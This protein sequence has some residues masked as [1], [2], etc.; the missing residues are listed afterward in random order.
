MIIGNYT[1]KFQMHYGS[2]TEESIH[3]V[4]LVSENHRIPEQKTDNYL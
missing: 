3:A 1:H 4:V 2:Q